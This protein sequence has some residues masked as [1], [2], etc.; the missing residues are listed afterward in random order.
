MRS[1]AA[2]AAI[3]AVALAV[4]TAQAGTPIKKAPA[5][6]DAYVFP[7]TQTLPRFRA[8]MLCLINSVRKA[9]HLPAL[10]RDSRLESVA[11]SQSKGNGGH[12][13]TLAEIGKRFEKKGYRP[14]AYNEGYAFLDDPTAPTPYGFLAQAMT[15]RSVPCSE[16]LDPRFRDIGIGVSHGTA[17]PFA[18]LALEFGL[19]QG[20]KQP[21]SDYTKAA[22]CPHKVPAP[23]FTTV[24]IDTGATPAAQSDGTVTAGLRCTAKTD[25]V[26][27]SAKLTLRH[28]NVSA[29]LDAPVTI[30]A[31]QASTLTFYF[32]P[33]DTQSELASSNP[34]ITLAFTASKPAEYSDSFDGPLLSR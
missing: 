6:K 7:A 28:V 9:Q 5:C 19:K 8:A 25:C 3:A 20:A 10:K 24:P 4:S 12:G 2:L 11:Q 27:D 1:A 30:S 17:G 22:S 31:G 26:I 32:Q 16:I 21:S 23:K 15:A 33:T 18:T 13:K 34:S 29:A 14:A